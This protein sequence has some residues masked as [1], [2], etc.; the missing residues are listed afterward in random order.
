MNLQ[1][2]VPRRT[3]LGEST[4]MAKGGKSG[5]GLYM[6]E[7]VKKGDYICEYVGEVISQ[8]ESEQRGGIYNKRNMSY[9]FEL[10]AG[11]YSYLS[12]WF[13]NSIKEEQHKLWTVI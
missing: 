6:G 10:N 2:S 8:E 11:T 12:F 1:R 13:K 5:W 4:L 9:L 7:P 3:L